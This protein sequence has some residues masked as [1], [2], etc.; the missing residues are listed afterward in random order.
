[1]HEIVEPRLSVASFA[2]FAICLMKASMQI[3]D[4]KSNDSENR[5]S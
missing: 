3:E 2:D 5:A 4:K 1:M